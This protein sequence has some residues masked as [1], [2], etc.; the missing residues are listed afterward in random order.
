FYSPNSWCAFC[1]SEFV[2]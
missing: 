1:V 2:D